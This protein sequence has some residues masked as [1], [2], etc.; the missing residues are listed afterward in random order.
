MTKLLQKQKIY[1]LYSML[2]FQNFYSD[3]DSQSKTV[4]RPINDQFSEDPMAKTDHDESLEGMAVSED[5][6]WEKYYTDTP[7]EWNAGILEVKPMS[8][9]RGN[10]LK[11]FFEDLIREYRNLS[12]QFQQISL[13]IGFQM[14]LRKGK[15]IRKPDIGFVGPDSLQMALDDCTYKGIFD[16]CV[17]FLS[18]SRP[19]EVK[20]DTEEKYEEYQEAGVKEFFILDRNE[21]HTAF[22]RLNKNGIY[23]AIDTSDGVVRSEV[24]HQFQFRIEHLYT[25]PDLNELINDPV[26]HHYVKRDYQ[27]EKKRAEVEKERAGIEKNRADNEKNRADSEKNRADSEKNR[28]DSEKKRADHTVKL[29]EEEK[30]RAEAYKQKLEELGIVL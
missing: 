13:E 11:I 16:L 6:Y 3:K 14:F 7:Y 23:E 24:L 10:L 5:E 29:L 21:T 19:S 27:E 25:R 8:D 17:E 22:Y 4:I 1:E 9:Y 30:K 20:R 2:F 12:I 18:D 28:A 15:K 26:Y